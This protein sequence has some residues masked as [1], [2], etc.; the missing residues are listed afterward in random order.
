MNKEKLIEALT[1]AGVSLTGDEK[2]A[3]L[4]ALYKEHGLGGDNADGKVIVWLKNTAY[5]NDTQRV[6]A[7]VYAMD[8]V[9]AR[10]AKLSRKECEIFKGD[11]PSRKI[12]D[13]A[14]WAG[15]K[16]IEDLTDEEFLNKVISEPQPYV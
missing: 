16:N 5:I 1:N 4:K 10:F 2:V 13:I 6:N 7:G 3:D 11:I 14:K 9:P 8:E 12:A 15:L